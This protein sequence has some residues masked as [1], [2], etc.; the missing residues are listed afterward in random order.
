MRVCLELEQDGAVTVNQDMEIYVI[1]LDSETL[2]Q[3]IDDE[4]T[5]C[6][7]VF[8]SKDILTAFFYNSD[9]VRMDILVYRAR[10]HQGASSYDSAF[11]NEEVL[12]RYLIRPELYEVENSL[13]GGSIKSLVTCDSFVYVRFESA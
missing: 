7:F 4:P 10:Q 5:S 13:S 12:S 1:A 9:L 6:H 3:S 2:K 11:F 8:P